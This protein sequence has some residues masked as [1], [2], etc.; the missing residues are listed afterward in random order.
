MAIPR[1]LMN[2]TFENVIEDK[3]IF[4]TCDRCGGGCRIGY[5]MCKN[6]REFLNRKC[7]MCD[8]KSENLKDYEW[9]R[10]KNAY[11]KIDCVI[12]Y[13]CNQ[14]NHKCDHCQKLIKKDEL[15]EVGFNKYFLHD[16]CLDKFTPLF[17][18]TQPPNGK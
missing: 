17:F 6:C 8:C 10:V 13:I 4:K 1:R 3:P 18:P 15:V 12:T 2:A 14:C 9:K 7:F 11:G 5:E 16:E